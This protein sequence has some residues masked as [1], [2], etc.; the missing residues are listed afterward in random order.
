MEAFLVGVFVEVV[1]RES[2][3][4]RLWMSLKE[5]HENCDDVSWILTGDLVHGRH[6]ENWVREQLKRKSRNNGEN[7]RWYKTKAQNG[8]C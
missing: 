1:E 8:R 7:K 3:V 4:Q 5:E 2:S 6:I